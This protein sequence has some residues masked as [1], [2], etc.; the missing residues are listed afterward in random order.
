[1]DGGNPENLVEYTLQADEEWCVHAIHSRNL[2]ARHPLP[3][4]PQNGS[5]HDLSHTKYSLT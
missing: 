1:M 2:Q 5:S 4:I 3:W